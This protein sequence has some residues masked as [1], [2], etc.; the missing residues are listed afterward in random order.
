MKGHVVVELTDI[1]NAEHVKLVGGDIVEVVV[2][3]DI[4][5]SAMIQC[6][7]APNMPQVAIDYVRIW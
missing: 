1:D 5:G 3:H 4:L 7:R 2:S 6:S